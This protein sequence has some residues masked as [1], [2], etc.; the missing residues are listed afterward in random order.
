MTLAMLLMLF[1]T[2]KWLFLILICIVGFAI[3][4]L[5]IVISKLLDNNAGN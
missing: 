3:W 2:N 4:R 5:H 1:K